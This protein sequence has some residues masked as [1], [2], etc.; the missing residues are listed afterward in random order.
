MEKIVLGTLVLNGNSVF[1]TDYLKVAEGVLFVEI[2]GNKQIVRQVSRQIQ[3]ESAGRKESKIEAFIKSS[4]Y[5][6]SFIPMKGR[7]KSQEIDVG[8][9]DMCSSI[10]LF[11]KQ[12]DDN[13]KLIFFQDEEREKVFGDWLSELPIPIPQDNILKKILMETLIDNEKIFFY[14]SE[15]GQINVLFAK[16]ECFNQDLLLIRNSIETIYKHLDCVA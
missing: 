6:R 16:D 7:M 12:H 10:I 9:F 1:L 11:Q 13:N 2:F 8:V 14:K 3:L 5:M 15:S 4:P